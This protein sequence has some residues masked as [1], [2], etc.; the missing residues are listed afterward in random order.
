MFKISVILSE[1]M[2]PETGTEL[3]KLG[4]YGLITVLSAGFVYGALVGL[5]APRF[6]GTVLYRLSLVLLGL[7]V[8]SLLVWTN[9]WASELESW[10]Q[11]ALAFLLAYFPYLVAA[12]GVILMA[13]IR[14]N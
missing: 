4:V 1:S 11:A 6:T 9:S 10:K 14:L 13:W 3:F 7:L 12:S 5:L 8:G 2:R